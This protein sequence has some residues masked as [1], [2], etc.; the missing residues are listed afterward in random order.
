MSL[1]SILGS[2][3]E[4]LDSE[5]LF[6]PLEKEFDL[7]AAAI[8]FGDDWGR[9]REVVG[10][11]DKPLVVFYIV[12]TNATELVRIPFVGIEAAQSDDLIAEHAGGFV[13]RQ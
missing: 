11:E 3:V 5:M 12:E 13:D 7:P 6:D 2:A 4:R 10:Q 9:K 8:E 1:Q